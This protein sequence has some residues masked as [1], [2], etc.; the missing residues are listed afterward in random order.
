MMSATQASR[1]FSQV[2]DDVEHGETVVV[3]RAGV[4]IAE[5]RPA[6]RG[7]GRQLVEL[8]ASMSTDAQ[9]ESDIERARASESDVEPTWHDD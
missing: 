3:T 2:L 8:L 7:N 9:W 5:I 1:S 4:R 6:G